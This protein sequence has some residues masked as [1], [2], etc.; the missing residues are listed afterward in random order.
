VIICKCSIM[1]IKESILNIIPG[2]GLGVIKFGINREELK[3]ILGEPQEVVSDSEDED[4]NGLTETWHYDEL[5]LSVSFYFSDEWSLETISVTSADYKLM[6]MNLIGKSVVEVTNF[7]KSKDF[8][9]I[10]SEFLSSE[11]NSSQQL[12]SIDDAAADFWFEEGE[13]IE[14]QWEM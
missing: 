7:L 13:L 6:E 2:E 1:I 8:G 4:E 14:I 11:E 9:E 3:E 5:D 12:L 10:K